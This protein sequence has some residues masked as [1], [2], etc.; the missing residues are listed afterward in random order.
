MNNPNSHFA[1][2]L[3]HISRPAGWWIL[4]SIFFAAAWFSR[5]AAWFPVQTILIAVS[6]SFPMSLHGYAL[7]DIYDR[8]SDSANARKKMW[9]QHPG[10]AKRMTPIAWTGGLSVILA[11]ATT[12]KPVP[13]ALGILLVLLSHAYSVPPIRL[14]NRPPLDSIANGFGYFF[15][16][17]LLGWSLHGSLRAIPLDVFAI[18]IAVAGIHSFA[19]IMDYSADKEANDRTM[20]TVFGKRGAAVFTALC[21]SITWI[22]T[23]FWYPAVGLGVATVV[24]IRPEER[25]AKIGTWFFYAMLIFAI[26][27]YYWFLIK[28]LG[29]PFHARGGLFAG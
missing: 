7:N 28:H 2:R 16:P 13:I 19:S 15:L 22:I 12:L 1:K 5:G 8:R 6:L 23:P 29:S 4:P 3:I 17:A 14:R 27:A 10:D 21:M 24:L 26:L 25:L 9:L 20:A 11:V 18:S